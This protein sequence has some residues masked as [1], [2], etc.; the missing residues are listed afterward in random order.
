MATIR[1]TRVL[2]AVA[3]IAALVAMFGS[4]GG[5]ESTVGFVAPPAAQG[6][7][8]LRGTAVTPAAAAVASYSALLAAAP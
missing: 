6:E 8:Q 3:A 5:Q 1:P 7:V 4:I 2:L